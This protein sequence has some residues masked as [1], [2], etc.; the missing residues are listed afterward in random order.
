MVGKREKC[1]RCEEPYISSK[2]DGLCCTG[3]RD[4]GGR[5]AGSGMMKLFSL[6]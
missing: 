1:S 4:K 6:G 2:K 3:I 5:E